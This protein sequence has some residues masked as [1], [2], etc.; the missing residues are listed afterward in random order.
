MPA[1]AVGPAEGL[2]TEGI[3][4][5]ALTFIDEQGM[6]AFS[7]RGL[8]ARL[9]VVPSA[10]YWHFTDRT[11]LLAA[12]AGRVM[13]EVRIPSAELA[14]DVWLEKLARSLRSAVHRHPAT[15]SLL[16]ADLTSNSSALFVV[17]EGT[18]GALEK[19]GFAGSDLIDSYNVYLGALSGFITMELASPPEEFLE[20][21]TIDRRRE[22]AQVDER[23]P[24][25]ARERDR[26]AG[27]FVTRW[28]SGPTAPMDAAFSA[29]LSV[30][31]A[32]LRA[33]SKT[34]RKPRTRRL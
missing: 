18:L 10:L 31:I 8:A 4:E 32:G 24:R 28:Q 21:W 26:L 19:A 7:M 17:V 3:T 15:S 1:R 34:V 12:V 13:S 9:D 20:S 25:I 2:T 27:G 29:L 14:W 33:H 11:E 5:A 23:F 16:G 30:I 22:L 6:A